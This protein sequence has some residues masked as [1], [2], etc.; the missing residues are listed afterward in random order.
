M[1]GF[2]IECIKMYELFDIFFLF[3]IFPMLISVHH[4]FQFHIQFSSSSLFFFWQKIVCFQ[5]LAKAIWLMKLH[6]S[7]LYVAM[8]LFTFRRGQKLTTNEQQQQKHRNEN[9]KK[10][11]KK[12]I[13]LCKFARYYRLY[14]HSKARHGTASNIW[15][16]HMLL[17]DTMR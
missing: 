14:F 7:K 4:V 9:I 1:V 17:N 2:F 6:Q 10:T 13:M 11:T 15:K 16:M 3:F 5:Q 8:R 12:K